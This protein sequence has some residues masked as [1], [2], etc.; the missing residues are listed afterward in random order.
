MEEE[1]VGGEIMER[2][3]PSKNKETSLEEALSESWS[4]LEK[5]LE[6]FKKICDELDRGE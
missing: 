3:E 5:E 6:E 1:A 4:F 2:G